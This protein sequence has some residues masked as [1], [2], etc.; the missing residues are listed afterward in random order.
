M[1][2]GRKWFT[3]IELLVVITILA[4]ISVV[5][6][7]NFSWSTSKAKNSKRLG[8]ITNIETALET[9]FQN[10]NYYPLP[11]VYSSWTNVWWYSS[12]ATA[13]PT[14][15]FTWSK[16]V[17]IIVSV[18]WSLIVWGWKVFESGWTDQ[19][20]AKWTMDSTVLSKQYLSQELL[21]PSLKDMKVWDS[22]TFKD[23]WIWGYIYSVYAK[24]NN[25]TSWNSNWKK[26]QAYNITATLSDDQK[27]YLTKTAWNFDKTSCTKCPDSLIWSGSVS[28]EEWDSYSWSEVSNSNITIPYPIEGF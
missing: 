3:L 4:I 8:D 17:D 24:P 14:S 18:S 5:A 1:K 12:W 21:D 25:P 9:F 11:S 13:T 6:Y 28:L 20:W 2:T 19:V 27:T 7:T 23:Y 26:W 16:D 10:N 15:T 22:S